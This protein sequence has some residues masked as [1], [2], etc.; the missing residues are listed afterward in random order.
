MG[1][2]GFGQ[3]SACHDWMSGWVWLIRP[4][5]M[6]EDKEDLC[7]TRYDELLAYC[8]QYIV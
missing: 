3:K 7:I 1:K 8:W 2:V 6:E 4:S 5:G